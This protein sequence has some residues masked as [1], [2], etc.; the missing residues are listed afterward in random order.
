MSRGDTLDNSTCTVVVQQQSPH[1]QLAWPSDVHA[2]TMRQV[3]VLWGLEAVSRARVR[4]RLL[5]E[6]AT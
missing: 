6:T 1:A 5:T 4:H 3:R 2:H